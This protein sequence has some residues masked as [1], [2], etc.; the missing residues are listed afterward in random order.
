MKCENCGHELVAGASFCGDC[1]AAY[2]PPHAAPMPP[3]PPTPPHP[4]NDVSPPPQQPVDPYASQQ[5]AP[6][7]LPPQPQ[8]QPMYQS[9]PP[10]PYYPYPGYVPAPKY[11]E[12]AIVAAIM[13]I[14]FA[15]LSIIFGFIA[16]GQ[17][18]RSNEQGKTLAV[19][20][21]VFGFLSV[22]FFVIYI[23]ILLAT[24]PNSY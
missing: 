15:P 2:T 8:P 24:L 22:L 21:I 3:V 9:P 1:G 17:I 12:M 4:V 14:F 18:K 19:V 20:G 7:P 23:G 16:L 6:A 5:Y 11:N 10:Q 13:I